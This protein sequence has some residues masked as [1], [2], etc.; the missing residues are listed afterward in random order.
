M[1]EIDGQAGPVGD[2]L[3]RA[4]STKILT[5]AA[6][7]L[8]ALGCVEAGA[9]P[10]PAPPKRAHDH[11]Q[12]AALAGPYP[13]VDAACAAALK[14]SGLPARPCAA[15]ALAAVAG[16]PYGAALL[17][18]EDPSDPRYAGSGAFFMAL[19]AEGAWFVTP[20][21]LDQQ[22]GGAGHMYLPA[23]TP[24]SAKAVTTG[25]AALVLYRFTDATSS[26]CNACEGP[27]HDKRTPVQ[28]EA[29]FLVC[30]RDRAGKPAC[31]APQKLD[32]K[33]ALA[34][35]PDGTL[36]LGVPGAA[37]KEYEIVF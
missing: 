14:A 17:R 35:A 1:I 5:A 10:P 28:T 21:P 32:T 37:A 7:A 25:G 6:T 2:N 34:L 12:A 23:L 20:R 19:G 13:T 3:R 27:E 18:S 26:V 36:S 4:M 29:V 33:S 30:G 16:A 24:A 9:A 11:L 15:T 22:N 31:T 8:L